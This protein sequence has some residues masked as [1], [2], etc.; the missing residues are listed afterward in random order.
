[1]SNK[2][3]KLGGNGGFIYFFFKKKVWLLVFLYNADDAKLI[4]GKKNKKD[5]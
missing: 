4:N 2:K 5:K 3:W 1:M